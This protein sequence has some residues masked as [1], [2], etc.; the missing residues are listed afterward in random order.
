MRKTL[1]LAVGLLACALTVPLVEAAAAKSVDKPLKVLMIGNSFSICV[2]EEAPKIAA[3]MGK[4]LDIAS[5]FVSG[6]TLSAHA[7]NLDATNRPYLVSCSYCGSKDIAQTPLA[8][9]CALD[10]KD[11]DCWK[12][13]LRDVIGADKWDVVTIQ[14]GSHE[15]WDATTYRPHADKLI[16]AVREL[17][18]QAEI[19]VQQ[20]WS[21][22]KGDSR[23]CDRATMGPGSWGFDQSGMYERLTAAYRKL[24]EENGFKIIP[25]GLAVQKFRQLRNITDYEGDVVGCVKP[26]KKD[27]KA[28]AGDKIHLNGRGQYLQGLVWVGALFNA[29]VTACAYKSEKM[30]DDLAIDLRICA[31]AAL[32]SEEKWQKDLKDGAESKPMKIV[33]APD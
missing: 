14:Q 20:T 11:R 12:G 6:C 16:A 30:E 33:G 26:S 10:A 4:R 24:A 8:T 22:C 17:A 7:K 28:L 18:P 23:I 27:P 13:N 29:N 25:T 31:A 19:R 3:S 9:V 21:Y 15:S 5:L 2:L 1:V 32:A